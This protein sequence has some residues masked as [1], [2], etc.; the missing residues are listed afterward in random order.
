MKKFLLII[1][2][3]FSTLLF[4]GCD[5]KQ[6]STSNTS[7]TQSSTSN[8]NDKKNTDVTVV[9]KIS[10]P[11]EI[12]NI[13]EN[14]LISM[15]GFHSMLSSYFFY[16]TNEDLL[17]YVLGVSLSIE[18][19]EVLTNENR[20]PVAKFQDKQ[21]TIQL[22]NDRLLI[23]VLTTESNVYLQ[24]LEKENDI[25]V[26]K[27][28]YKAYKP[29]QYNFLDNFCQMGMSP[30][31]WC[32]IPVCTKYYTGDYS[33]DET[34]QESIVKLFI[35]KKSSLGDFFENGTRF[36]GYI[37]K[38]FGVFNGFYAVI[39]DGCGF[40]YIECEEDVIIDGVTFHYSDDNRIY[41]IGGSVFSLEEAYEKNIITHDVL[42]EISNRLNG[43]ND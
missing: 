29:K 23:F 41:I 34:M 27:Y 30:N 38:S 40:N 43:R 15:E 20:D 19:N 4:V 5:K 37:R 3:A 35:N 9:D 31:L 10:L 18:F 14:D 33:I 39:I 2:L 21:V 11:N 32:E 13:N 8:N 6:S 7:V 16:S 12:R 24:Y 36:S 22:T 26:A 1:L 28:E 17:K 25:Y 42:V